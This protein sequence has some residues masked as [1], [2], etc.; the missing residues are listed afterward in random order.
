MQIARFSWLYRLLER[1]CLANTST[2]AATAP[3][4]PAT[5]AVFKPRGDLYNAPDSAPASDFKVTAHE[6]HASKQV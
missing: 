6:L 3:M 2:D 1:F 4:A 5:P